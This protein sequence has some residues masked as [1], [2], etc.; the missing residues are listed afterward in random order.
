M[1]DL[2]FSLF[3]TNP[4]AG[5]SGHDESRVANWIGKM[6]QLDVHKF[7]CTNFQNRAELVGAKRWMVRGDKSGPLSSFLA[8]HDWKAGIVSL[9]EVE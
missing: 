5:P 1:P 6:L 2:P 3:S 9:D 7:E 4:A 8:S